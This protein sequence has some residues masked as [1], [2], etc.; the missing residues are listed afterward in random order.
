MAGSGSSRSPD[1]SDPEIDFWN[2]SVLK[3]LK[4]RKDLDGESYE[5]LAKTDKDAHRELTNAD[6]RC[7]VIA[8]REATNDLLYYVFY[9]LNSGSVS[10]SAHN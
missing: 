5:S 8:S 4:L 6:V 1:S 7:A 2:K 9:R 10:M 3:N